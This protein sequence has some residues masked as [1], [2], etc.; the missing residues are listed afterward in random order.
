MELPQDAYSGPFSK[1][2]ISGEAPA[3]LP[4]YQGAFSSCKYIP[5][6]SYEYQQRNAKDQS[7]KHQHC[8]LNNIA[9]L[10][11]EWEAHSQ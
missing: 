10:Q 9:S 2:D 8:D 3:F 5:H 4:I 11:Q 6:M 1:L 7:C